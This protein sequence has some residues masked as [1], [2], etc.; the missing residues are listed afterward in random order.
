MAKDA[1]AGG[2]VFPPTTPPLPGYI[3]STAARSIGRPWV[4][5]SK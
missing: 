3:R 2:P 1:F 5:R 4:Y